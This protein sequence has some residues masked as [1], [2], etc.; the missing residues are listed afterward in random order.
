MATMAATNVRDVGP[1][2]VQACNN[3][4]TRID[5]ANIAD[6]PYYVEKR[7]VRAVDN[8]EEFQYEEVPIEELYDDDKE[9]TLD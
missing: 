1:K 4:S 6:V 5:L 7:Y 3:T 9:D 2:D 8:G